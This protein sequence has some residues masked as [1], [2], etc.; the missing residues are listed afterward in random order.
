MPRGVGSDRH[1]G[2]LNSRQT[3]SLRAFKGVTFTTLRAG[4]A[5]KT[6]G[7]PVKGFVPSRSGMAGYAEILPRNLRVLLEHRS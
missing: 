3:R 2:C 5:L 4:L 1:H 7:S 6:V